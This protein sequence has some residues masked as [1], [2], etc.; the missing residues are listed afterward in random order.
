LTAHY[1]YG[2]GHYYDDIHTQ[3]PDDKLYLNGTNADLI[4]LNMGLLAGYSLPIIKGV[5]LTGQIGFSQYIA[6]A[7][8]IPDRI[9]APDWPLGYIPSNYEE[10]LISAAFPVK[11]TIGFMPTKYLEIGFAAGFYIEPDYH[12]AIAGVYYGPQIS[13]LF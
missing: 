3:H 6:T 2:K 1:N 11:F 4:I 9:Y 12:P 13:V 5:N 7:L 8:Y 10:T